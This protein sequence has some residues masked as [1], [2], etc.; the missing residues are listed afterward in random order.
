VA[1][2]LGHLA[3][4]EEAVGEILRLGLEALGPLRH[5]LEGA[6]QSVPDARRLAASLLGQIG[7]PEAVE[8]LRRV[9]LWDYSAGLDPVLAFSESIV[10][11]EAA[12]QLAN[13]E[14]E[15]AVQDLLGA[16]QRHHLPAA[17]EAL[18]HFH[19]AAAIPALVTA[20]EN[21]LVVGTAVEVIR[22]FGAEAEPLLEAAVRERH[23]GP[24]GEESRI[25]RQR[26]LRAAL[27]LGEMGGLQS[28]ACLQEGLRDP[29][30][31]L[32]AAAAWALHRITPNGCPDGCLEAILQG[33]LL[34]DTDLRARCRAT[35]WALGPA[36]VPAAFAALSIETMPDFYGV[37]MPLSWRDKAW[38]L[39]LVLEHLPHPTVDAEILIQHCDAWILAR[40]LAQVE[41]ALDGAVVER[42]LAHPDPRV[43]EGLAVALGRTGGLDAARGLLVLLNGNHP[44][45]R[46]A[47]WSAAQSLFAQ[48]PT[49]LHQAWS[50]LRPRPTWLHRFRARRLLRSCLPPP[51]ATRG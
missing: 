13:L 33:G 40:G 26:R 14:G 7:G 37:P 43:R 30:P 11:N 17:A 42:L 6:P 49:L 27:L 19:A 31:A 50:S 18:G 5:Y 20:L 29:H 32:R 4:S 22:T 44:R 39:S 23:D 12:R 35:A 46:R 2:H 21:D 16:F 45:V 48:D 51:G 34:A 41:R 8:G 15:R 24:S 1:R 10:R 36:A 3:H 9:M 38:L 28:L 25:S 47:A